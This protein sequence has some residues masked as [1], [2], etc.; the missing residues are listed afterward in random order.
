MKLDKKQI[1]QLIVLG[2]LVLGCIGYVS[3]TVLKPPAIDPVPPQGKAVAKSEAFAKAKKAAA[4]S[5]VMMPTATFPDLSAPIPRRDP[6]AVQT[7]ENT[8]TPP[9]K[10]ADA[11]V[12]HVAEKTARTASTKVPPLIPIGNFNTSSSLS[13]VPSV[14]SRDPNF[15]LTGVIRGAENVAIIRVGEER[16]VVKQGQYIDGTYRVVSVSDDGAV[17]ACGNRRIY[18]RLGG[19]R[20]A[21]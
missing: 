20:N 18:L 12:T 9:T 19:V 16:H 5:V 6:F 1:P 3:F 11:N 2:L 14:E 8:G 15:V 17:L 13:V 10:P 7:L 21:S 4:Q